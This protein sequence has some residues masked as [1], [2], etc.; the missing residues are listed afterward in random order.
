[1]GTFRPTHNSAGLQG[2]SFF[3]RPV[4]LGQAVASREAH[5]G[6]KEPARPDSLTVS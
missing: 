6:K 1:M 4:N 3:A 5:M 2:A